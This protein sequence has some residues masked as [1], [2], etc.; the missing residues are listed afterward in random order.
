MG[1][2]AVGREDALPCART[3]GLRGFARTHAKQCVTVGGPTEELQLWCVRSTRATPTATGAF[4]ASKADTYLGFEIDE[5]LKH[6]PKLDLSLR[7]PEPSI[8]H[9]GRPIKECDAV[10]EPD[11]FV[12]YRLAS[13]TRPKTVPLFSARNTSTARTW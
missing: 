11:P 2:R 9:I 10:S 6:A 8:R 12:A 13:H 1:N 4:G 3:R 7:S 5:R